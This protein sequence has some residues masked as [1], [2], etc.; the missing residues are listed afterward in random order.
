M[1]NR[2]AGTAIPVHI[3]AQATTELVGDSSGIAEEREKCC[4]DCRERLRVAKVEEE[5]EAL[6]S[7]LYT[8]M[9]RYGSQTYLFGLVLASVCDVLLV[10]HISKDLHEPYRRMKTLFSTYGVIVRS[11]YGVD[12]GNPEG[13]SC[14]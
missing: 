10:E 13:M 2:I 8:I 11:A 12:I 6:G 9:R 14:L 7:A 1:E 3:Y 4:F 5:L